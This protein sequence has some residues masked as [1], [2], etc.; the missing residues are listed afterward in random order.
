MLSVT[1]AHRGVHT[2]HFLLHLQAVFWTVFLGASCQTGQ[3]GPSAPGKAEV[4]RQG[5]HTQERRQ[6]GF[7]TRELCCPGRPVP[8]R[9][10]C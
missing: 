9:L 10:S 8:P 6:W 1:Y 2:P 4:K 7:A 3:L 5:S